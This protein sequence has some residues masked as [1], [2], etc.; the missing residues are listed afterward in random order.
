ML[1]RSRS[2][3]VCL[4]ARGDDCLQ[5]LRFVF[6]VA[7]GNLHQIGHQIVPAFQLHINLTKSIRDPVTQL[8]QAVVNAHQT[9]YQ[10]QANGQHNPGRRSHASP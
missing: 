5:G 3:I 6:H 1:A 9:Y 2:R 8:N 4:I 10:Y 7:A